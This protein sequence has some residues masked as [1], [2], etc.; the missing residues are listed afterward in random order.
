MQKY[1]FYSY[2]LE[3]ACKYILLFKT[4]LEIPILLQSV[5]RSS[6]MYMDVIGPIILGA[7]TIDWSPLAT[8]H[9][10][11]RACWKFFPR[12]SLDSPVATDHHPDT[13][14][15]SPSD[16]MATPRYNTR[17]GMS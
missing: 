13:S 8:V 2:V 4:V 17:P 7:S 12:I 9:V 1:I 3:C 10:V 16:T 15:T 14:L 5:G 6:Y 11:P